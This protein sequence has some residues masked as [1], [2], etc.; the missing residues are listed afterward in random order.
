MAI[1]DMGYSKPRAYALLKELRDSFVDELKNAY[2]SQ[3][4]NYGSIIET[5]DKPY[6]FIRFGKK[7]L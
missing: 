2:G 6:Q 1:C 4:I 5:I 7:T 3:A